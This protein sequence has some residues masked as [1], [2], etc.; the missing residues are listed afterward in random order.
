MLDSLRGYNLAMEEFGNL[1]ANIQNIIN[2][3]RH[4]KTSIFL[5]NEQERITGDLQ[6]TEHGVSYMADNILLIRYAESRGE[7]IRVISCFKKR[8]GG[9]HP[10]IR[11]FSITPKGIVVGEKLSQWSG[12]L[13]GLPTSDSRQDKPEKA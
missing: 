1:L 4:E 7:V 12:L 9:F 6:I 3:V 2:F 10:D 11:Q 5:I 8:L 13:S